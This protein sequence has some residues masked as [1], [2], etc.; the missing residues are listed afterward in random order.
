M[1]TVAA[2]TDLPAGP[3]PDPSTARLSELL[4]P[5][6]LAE[7][8][9][10]A[11]LL[12]LTPPPTHRLLGRP[13]CQAPGC[14]TTAMGR[15]RTC[16]SCSRRLAACGLGEDQLELLPIRAYPARGPDACR[17]SGCGREWISAAA[18]LCRTHL[19]QRKATGLTVEG[20]CA[21]AQPQP[22]PAHPGCSVASCP[23][24]R[25]HPDSLYCEP[26]QLRLR[27][28]RRTQAGFD[29]ASWALVDRPIDRGGQI[30]LG[31]LAPRVVVEVLVGLQ[32]RCRVDGVRTKEGDLRAVV[33]DLR[34]QQVPS[35]A[36]YM[37]EQEASPAFKG[38]VNS[39]T[40]HARRAL[41]STE[42]EVGADEWDLAV[43]GHPGTASFTSI[44]QPWLREAA[45]RWAAEDLPRRRVRAGRRTSGGLSVRHHIRALARLSESLR[46]RPDRGEIPAAL[47]R[48]DMDAFL[49]GW[50][51]W[52]RPG[53]SA[54]MPGSGPS[55]RSAPS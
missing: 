16:R 24:Q 37:P 28:A 26:H 55:E 32:Q 29:E 43:F 17:V 5:A 44:S 47:G 7:A 14:S 4:D 51:F 42:T 18:G 39:L 45:K 22:L 50:R 36:G 35:L 2:R 21:D 53:N 38:L 40:S 33:D 25:R 3:G 9:W 13:I 54:P 12:V 41:A 46:M 15:N 11:A 8:G 10:D 30:P 27:T 1:T 6:F 34:R 20:F 23:R 49:H 31:G 19:D 52:P 48:A